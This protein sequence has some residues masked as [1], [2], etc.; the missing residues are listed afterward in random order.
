MSFEE[1]RNHLKPE[2][3]FH[4]K[5]AELIERGT[6]FAVSDMV[7]FLIRL[8]TVFIGPRDHM[9]VGFCVV[10]AKNL[11]NHTLKGSPKRN[12]SCDHS[13]ESFYRAEIPSIIH[14]DASAFFLG[15]ELLAKAN[16][17]YDINPLA[18]YNK[19]ESLP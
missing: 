15:S 18:T 19:N 14:L 11:C 8:S 7:E 12:G 2:S 3:R 16:K 13:S 1:R 17:E 9:L 4:V 10:E 6:A 5:T